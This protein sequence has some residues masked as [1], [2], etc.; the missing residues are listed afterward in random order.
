MFA[1][2]SNI[3]ADITAAAQRRGGGGVGILYG[4]T[5]FR[6]LSIAKTETRGILRTWGKALSHRSR[7]RL[8][9][10]GDT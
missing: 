8:P 7:H 9:H 3:Y 1:Q 4:R 5:R 2:I 10:I 6:V